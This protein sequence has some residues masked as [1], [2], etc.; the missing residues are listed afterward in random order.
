MP[1][2]RLG[3]KVLV[4]LRVR[5]KDARQKLGSTG[6]RAEREVWRE[7][8]DRFVARDTRYTERVQVAG[9]PIHHS[10]RRDA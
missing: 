4:Y 2:P 10:S 1:H 3:L 5:Q 8:A 6:F 7:S 9:P